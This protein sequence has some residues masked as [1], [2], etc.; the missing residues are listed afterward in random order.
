MEKLGMTK[1]GARTYAYS[2]LPAKKILG[3]YTYVD[4]K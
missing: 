2:I 1:L 4:K 3:T